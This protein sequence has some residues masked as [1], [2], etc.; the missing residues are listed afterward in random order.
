MKCPLH[1]ASKKIKN[2]HVRPNEGEAVAITF[3]ITS[4]LLF[5]IFLISCTKVREADPEE[6][7]IKSVREFSNQSIANRDT[8][9]IVST[10]TPDFHA[11]TSRN[12]EVTGSH[13]MAK[14]F[15]EEFQLRPDVSYVR[16]PL[17]VR[18]FQPWNSASERG[19]WV[20]TW[21]DVDGTIEVS[22]IYYAKWVRING[23]WLIRAEIFTPRKCVGGKYCEQAPV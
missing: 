7:V 2:W 14:K 22:G 3:R 13:S 10:L 16:T 1:V 11:I 20:G 6:E 4:L 5:L 21:K 23:K 19:K 17:Q 15:A 8:T 9:G 18:I 12:A